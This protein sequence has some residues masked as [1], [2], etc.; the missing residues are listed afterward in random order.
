MVFVTMTH[1]V[2]KWYDLCMQY[3]ITESSVAANSDVILPY[4]FEPDSHWSSSEESDSDDT[5]SQASFSERLDN[6]SWC[7]CTKCLPMPR[8]VECIC[9][10]E[11]PEVVEGL[12]GSDGC[13]T[14]LETFKTFCLNKDVLYT[15]LV[16]MHTVRGDEVETPISNR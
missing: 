2:R 6:T 10:H 13:I 9:C 12:E 16:I 7:S 5:E 8:A 3:T 4:R 14:C 11:L 1:L 15:A